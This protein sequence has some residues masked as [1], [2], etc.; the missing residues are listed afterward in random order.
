MAKTGSHSA[1]RE[2]HIVTLPST[3]SS[4][5]YGKCLKR[6]GLTICSVPTLVHKG[7]ILLSACNGT[8]AGRREKKGCAV[9]QAQY[10]YKKDQASLNQESPFI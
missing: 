10:I 1:V 7:G 2:N 6:S 8:K 9:S 4:G 3:S 5:K